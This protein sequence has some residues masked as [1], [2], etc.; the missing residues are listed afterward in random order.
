[1]LYRSLAQ[2]S[3]VQLPTNQLQQVIEPSAGTSSPEAQGAQV[4]HLEVQNS[5]PFKTRPIILIV[6]EVYLVFAWY[7][8]VCARTDPFS[9]STILFISSWKVARCREWYIRGLGRNHCTSGRCWSSNGSVV[10]PLE[11]WASTH[12]A[13]YF[14]FLATPGGPRYWC[15]DSHVSRKIGPQTRRIGTGNHLASMD[16]VPTALLATQQANTGMILRPCA[17]ARDPHDGSNGPI[18]NG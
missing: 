5:R 17:V 14:S 6:I 11:S 7:H 16:R 18:L 8:Y 3:Q 1:M 13:E 4:G 2:L 10:L 15:W 12:D 9:L